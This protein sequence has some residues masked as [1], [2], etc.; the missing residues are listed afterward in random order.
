M[1][2]LAIAVFIL[3]A[4]S[5]PLIVSG[6]ADVNT[7]AD[8]GK[9]TVKFMFVPVFI[10]KINVK[11]IKDK[12]NGNY[13]ER[14]NI[15]DSGEEHEAKQEEEKPPASGGKLK[16]FLFALVA[17]IVRR[18]RLRA[19]DCKANIGTGDAA[20]S[21]MTASTVKIA[22]L[23]ACAF[24]GTDSDNIQI[25][26]DYNEECLILD[27]FG[28]ISLCFADII[29]AVCGAVSDMLRKRTSKRSYY[30]NTVTD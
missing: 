4:I 8:Y 26:P 2:Y 11:N 20:V 15:E 6:S 24:F 29:I 9:I 16:A 19:L 27:F 13:I 1:I 17:N 30:A 7:D 3:H 28:I 12:L 23:Q 22:L 25:S 5:L 10:K 14:S 18:I 21:A